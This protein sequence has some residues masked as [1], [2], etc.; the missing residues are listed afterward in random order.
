[1]ATK[2]VNFTVHG[3]FYHK[4]AIESIGIHN[5]DFDLSLNEFEKKYPKEGTEAYKYS[6]NITSVDLVPEPNNPHDPNAIKVMMNGAHVGY[7]TAQ[8]TARVKEYLESGNIESITGKI[9]GGPVRYTTVS[10]NGNY[11]AQ[12]RDTNY[13]ARFTMHLT[14]SV[15]S[16][17]TVA[18]AS[19]ASGS[20][21]L[22]PI[23]MG[24]SFTGII[25]ALL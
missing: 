16:A 10:S 18:K 1:M 4:D 3:E 2:H 19:A 7:I 12:E 5:P 23:L 17:K 13:D 11:Y 25:I 24:L 9:T 15:P 20:G 6:F 14:D 8:G 22:I 21:C